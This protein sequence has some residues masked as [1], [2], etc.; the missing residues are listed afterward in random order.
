VPPDG[1]V[2][3]GLAEILEVHLSDESGEPHGPER[4]E[5]ALE[6]TCRC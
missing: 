6:C 1:V 3:V 4:L 5:W 2:P